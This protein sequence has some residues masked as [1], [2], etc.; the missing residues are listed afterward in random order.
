MEMEV[1]QIHKYDAHNTKYI[2]I[3]LKGRFGPNTRIYNT[4]IKGSDFDIELGDT[5]TVWFYNERFWDFQVNW[6]TLSRSDGREIGQ[7]NIKLDVS[8][9]DSNVYY[10]TD[11]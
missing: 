7:S 1:V 4:E 9:N 8:S 6:K 10:F 11:S 3:Q 5:V 2:L